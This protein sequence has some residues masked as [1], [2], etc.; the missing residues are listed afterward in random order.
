MRIVFLASTK[1]DLRWFKQYYTNVF[2]QGKHKADSQFL[3][4]QKV[5]KTTPLVGHASLTI[6]GVREFPILRTPF[7]LIYR[8]KQDR[9][10]L[11]RIIDKRSDWP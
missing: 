8:L 11:L 4:I 7:S 10:E 2:P 6:E 3:A 9:I 5:L 1:A